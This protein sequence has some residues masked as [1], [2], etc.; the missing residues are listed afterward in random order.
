[1]SKISLTSITL[2]VPVVLPVF[3]D[4][5]YRLTS[6]PDVLS[7]YT[8]VGTF[9][10]NPD[11]TFSAA[12][13]I[14]GLL[15]STEYTVWASIECSNT[16]ILHNFTTPASVGN[17]L[18]S[19]VFKR[20][21]SSGFSGTTV[22]Y[23]VPADTFFA[24]NLTDANNLALAYIA[25]NGQNYANSDESGTQCL[26]DSTASTI[27]IDFTTSGID[28]DLC[29]YTDTAGIAEMNQIVASTIN[30]G[31]LQYPNDGRDPSECLFLSSDKLTGDPYR[32]FGINIAYLITAYP[33][34][35]VFE[36][37]IRGRADIGESV[38]VSYAERPI[39]EGYLIM[40][41]SV[42]AREPGVS[43]GSSI[44]TTTTTNITSGG[45]GTVGLTVGVPV[46]KLTYTVSSNDLV[47][48]TY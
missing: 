20:A 37:I 17:A 40:G 32:R 24:D 38:G 22:N 10:V 5:K 29:M 9:Q 13:I 27:L 35:D 18:Q 47:A 36:F 3:V 6:D 7:S 1:M 46:L 4:I 8:D 42:G 15:G 25:A 39:S 14:N 19:Q 34:I 31:P 33:G 12:V 43:S 2:G 16:S 30:G 28:Y 45:D 41:G 23:V 48:T 11:G 21:C 26:P 44:P